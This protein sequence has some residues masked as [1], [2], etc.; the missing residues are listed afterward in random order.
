MLS[1]HD[2]HSDLC[3]TGFLST[4]EAEELKDKITAAL[5]EQDQVRDAQT[6]EAHRYME[7]A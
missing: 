4:S 1:I 7:G 6:E 3:T 2:D 5:Y